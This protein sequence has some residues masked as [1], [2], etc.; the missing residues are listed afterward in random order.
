M[1]AKELLKEKAK[2]I[3]VAAV[4]ELSETGDKIWNVYFLNFRK[5]ILTTILVTSKGY[6]KKESGEMIK[7]SVLRHMFDTVEPESGIK[8]EP[9]MEEMFTLNNEYWISFY[10]GNEL[11]DRKFIF[12]ADTIQEKYLVDIPLLGKKGVLIK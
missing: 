1:K 7:S 11:L 2:E 10:S 3:G 5:E 9:I 4:Q 8:V 6:L 12:L